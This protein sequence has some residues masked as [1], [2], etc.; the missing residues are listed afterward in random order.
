MGMFNVKTNFAKFSGKHLCWSLFHF[1]A[2]SLKFSIKETP[3]QVLS[4]KFAEDLKNSFFT[5]HLRV[6][7]SWVVSLCWVGEYTLKVNNKSAEFIVHNQQKQPPEMF[8]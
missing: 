7:V 8:C 2:N 6:T 1:Q 4:C 3:A 5:E